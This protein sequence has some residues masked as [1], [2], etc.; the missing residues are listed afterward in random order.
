MGWQVTRIAL[1]AVN[2]GCD[3]VDVVWSK[4]RT[5][6][7]L[8]VKSLDHFLSCLWF[9][10]RHPPTTSTLLPPAASFQKREVEEE[11]H[12][13]KKASPAGERAHFGTPDPVSVPLSC[14]LPS[15]LRVTTWR[16]FT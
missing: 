8:Y 14:P 15:L 16:Q 9:N 6:H 2:L 10:G 3:I 13:N 7:V 4:K 1:A 5:G 12:K 11:K